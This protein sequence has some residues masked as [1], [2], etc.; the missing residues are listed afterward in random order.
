MAQK[1]LFLVWWPGR[2]KSSKKLN[3]KNI[4][5][6]LHIDRIFIYM[7]SFDSFHLGFVM[8]VIDNLIFQAIR[9]SS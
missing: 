8:Q 2:N 6:L 1:T 9:G 3:I 7:R 5:N 4:K